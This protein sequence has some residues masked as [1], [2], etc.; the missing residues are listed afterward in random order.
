MKEGRLCP[1]CNRFIMNTCKGYEWYELKEIRFC[2]WQVLF[3][4]EN[5]HAYPTDPYTSGYTEAPRTSHR[6]GANAP[7][8]SQ[9]VVFA[10]LE[11]RIEKTGTD[12][13]W[14]ISDV[15]KGVTLR[16]LAYEP[17][18]ALHYCAGWTRKR[19]S[20]SAWAKQI[21]YRHNSTTKPLQKQG[22]IDKL[23]LRV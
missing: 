3:L 8:E 6:I 22:G 2:R 7:F 16:E 19:L 13:K 5:F 4:L 14:L 20:Y 17:R 15:Q 1:S 21:K 12:G 9:A 18:R 23:P 10:E 11:Y